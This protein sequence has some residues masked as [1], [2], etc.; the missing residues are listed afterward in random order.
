MAARHLLTTRPGLALLVT[1][2]LVV[3]ACGNEDGESQDTGDG[4]DRSDFEV[5]T[6]NA[7]LA[8]GFVDYSVERA[9]EVADAISDVE[10]Q[11]IAV[12][13]VWDPEDVRTVIDGSS[14]THPHSFFLDPHRGG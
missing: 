10:A 2:A 14:D 9:P 1:L 7:G 4:A 13:E 8:R 11:V 3:S 6:W 12:Q 5:V